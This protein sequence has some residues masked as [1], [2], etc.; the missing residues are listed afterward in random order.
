MTARDT[1]TKVHERWKDRPDKETPVRAVD[2]EHIEQGIKNAADNRAM[3]C[4]YDDDHIKLILQQTGSKTT[5]SHTNIVGIGY[6]GSESEKESYIHTLDRE[7]NAFFAGDVENGDGVSLNRL[8]AAIERI[9]QDI[10]G[11]AS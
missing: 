7:G 6:V 10:L 9:D 8:K 4:I 3:K 1:Y 2:L 5:S 11:G